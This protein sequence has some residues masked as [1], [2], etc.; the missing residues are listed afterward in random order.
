MR[1]YS[2][3]FYHPPVITGL[4]ETSHPEWCSAGICPEEI[5]NGTAIAGPH[6]SSPSLG[7]LEGWNAPVDD[8]VPF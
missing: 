1:C 4:V 7:D 2:C 3:E 5:E 6:P 8:D